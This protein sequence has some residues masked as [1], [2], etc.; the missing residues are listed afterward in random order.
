MRHILPGYTFLLIILIYYAHSII[1][2]FKNIFPT[3]S[4]DVTAAV[5]VV[6][7]GAPLGFLVSQP[8]HLFWKFVWYP[9]KSS[10]IRLL[11]KEK[12][13]KGKISKKY[14]RRQEMTDYLIVN[15]AKEKEYN[16]MTRRL[17]LLN[18]L[19]S[20]IFAIMF[21]WV[22]VGV[23]TYLGLFS[24]PPPFLTLHLRLPLAIVSAIMIVILM[25]GFW[26]MWREHQSIG[27]RIIRGCAERQGFINGFEDRYFD[28]ASPQNP[29]EKRS[30]SV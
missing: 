11:D 5:I 26:D 29:S 27:V 15:C 14:L 1:L 22:G 18:T 30:D 12:G 17:D 25:A 4:G 24:I 2:E 6:I 21:A 10:M 13:S 8:W 23:I 9:C 19:G 20:E 28:T 3:T 16:F 7:G